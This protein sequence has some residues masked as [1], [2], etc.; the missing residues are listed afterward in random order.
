MI[1]ASR[2]PLGGFDCPD[3]RPLTA[4]RARLFAMLPA[5]DAR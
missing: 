2:L 5:G 3:S 1:N 4:L